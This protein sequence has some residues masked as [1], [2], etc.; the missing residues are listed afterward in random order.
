MFC[1]AERMKMEL[2]LISSLRSQCGLL[3]PHSA[4][5]ISASATHLHLKELRNNRNSYIYCTKNP[6]CEGDQRVREQSLSKRR[7]LLL[8]AATF[9]VASSSLSAFNTLVAR[10]QNEA[11][12]EFRVYTDDVN[13]FKISI[14]SDW[15]IGSGEGDGVRS[16]IAFYPQ[17]PSSSS[18]VSIMI[19]TLGADFTTLGSFGRVDAFADNLVSGLDRSWKRPPG[20]KAKLIDCKSANGLYYIDYTLQNPG[21]SMR[22]LSTVLGIANNGLYNRLY[23]ITGQ[24]VDDESEKY[25]AKVE[26]AVASFRF[27]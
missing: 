16:L 22:H 7:D 4:T 9:L 14:P 12:T 1:Q 23:T 24:C 5:P 19:T 3:F 15:E 8:Q 25:C 17:E 27:I 21:E 18:N 20:V 26:K 2:A 6:G 11:V 13:K 10:A